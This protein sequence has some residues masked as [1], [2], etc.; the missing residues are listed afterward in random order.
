MSVIIIY[1]VRIISNCYHYC[2]VEVQSIKDEPLN[3]ADRKK[4]T[5]FVS[6][7]SYDLPEDQLK[8]ILSAA[9]EVREVRLALDGKGSSRGFGYV[10]FVNEV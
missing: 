10:E 8:E 5:I 6:N 4:C 7:I 9:G 3:D 1:V 2:A